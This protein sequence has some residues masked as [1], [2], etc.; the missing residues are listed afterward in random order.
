MYDAEF[1]IMC[2]EKETFKHRIKL[3]LNYGIHNCNKF[4]VKMVLLLKENKESN[5]EEEIKSY[6]KNNLKFEVLRFQQDEP[7]FKKFSYFT[8]VAPNRLDD[9]R[10][11]IGMDEDSIT[12]ID[13]LI[14]HLDE[15]YDWQEKH[16]VSTAPMNN[17]QP[18]EYDLALVFGKQHWYSPIGG[19]YH[20]WEICCLSQ[21]S[22]K[23]ILENPNSNKILNMRKKIS[24][25]W[26]DHCMG[27]AAKFAKIYPTGSNFISGKPMIAEHKILGGWII[28]C[29]HIYELLGTI[30]MLPILGTR[31][32]GKFGGRKIFLSEIIEEKIEDRGFYTLEKNGVIISPNHKPLGVWNFKNEQLG[33]HWFDKQN[34][35]YFETEKSDLSIKTDNENQ[36]RIIAG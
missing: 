26:G 20:E 16:Y 27:I 11:F 24:K 22:I 14:N 30:K 34:P 3:F 31:E 35:T 9:A 17:T 6:E 7:S 32:N 36:Y 28:H 13:A 1:H 12:D 4:K 21:K 33:L 8:E 15:D 10:W 29:H 23:T 25:G 18:M 5:L 19:P 2:S